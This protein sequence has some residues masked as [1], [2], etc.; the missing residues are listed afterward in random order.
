VLI[1]EPITSVLKMD[2]SNWPRQVTHQPLGRDDEATGLT[3][4]LNHREV[5][6]GKER[7]SPKKRILGMT[8]CIH[9]CFNQRS[10]HLFTLQS[11]TELGD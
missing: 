4:R 6:E 2:Y 7:G 10:Y 8:T 11:L 5:G 1:P 9:Q 3:R